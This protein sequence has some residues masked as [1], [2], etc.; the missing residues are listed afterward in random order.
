MAF[1][2]STKPP[3]FADLKATLA[4]SRDVDNSL[5]QTVQEIIDRL[6]SAQAAVSTTTVIEGGGGTGGGASDAATYLTKDDEATALPNSR[7][8]LARYGLKFDDSVPNKRTID[9]DL[10][11]LGSFAAGPLYSDGDV[12]VGPDNIAYLCV[13]PTNDPPVTW[14][15]VGIATVEG[16]PGPPGPIGPQGIQGPVGP[17]GIQGPPGP[18][19]GAVADAT[20]W[21]VSSHVSL[22]NARALN[23]HTTGYV[24]STVGEPSVVATIPLTDTT[25][26]LPDNRL[27]SNVALKNINNNF[28]A[29]TFASFSDIRG[30]YSTLNFIDI[31]APLNQKVWR[32]LN[33][34]SNYFY[35]EALT[36]DQSTQVASFGFGRGGDFVASFFKGNGVDVTNL[37]APNIAT[38]IVNPARLGSGV[39]NSTTFLRGDSTWQPLD[40]F[41]SGLIVLSLSPCPVGWT[42]VASLDGRFIRGNV[43]AGGVGGTETHSHASGSLAVGSHTHTGSVNIGVSGST[44][45]DGNHSHRVASGISGT[46]ASTGQANT[47]DAGGSFGTNAVNHTHNF[48]TSF[49]VDSSTDGAHSHSLNGSGSGNFT[50]DPASPGIGGETE[51]KSHL[52]PF[53]DVYFCQKN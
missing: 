1:R 27:T 18:A 14:P 41:P 6:A 12:V 38:G 37:H 43:S 29:Q 21:L 15:G 30:S 45:N 39:A 10:E 16:P 35:F 2:R 40:A 47:A 28:V 8:F 33:Y 11:Y 34:H 52:P 23:T 19:G 3:Q 32:I 49:S 31:D 9:L 22:P 13:K 26:I 7:Q 51:T 53:M 42:R 44:S 24:R 25:G 46:T 20:Y 17:Q 4:Q 50:T 36:D 48:D 5:Y